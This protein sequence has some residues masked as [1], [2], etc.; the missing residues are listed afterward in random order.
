LTLPPTA[1]IVL[2]PLRD[3]LRP[4][5]A[6]VLVRDPE[7]LVDDRPRDVVER[8]RDE[9]EPR[10]RELE[11][12][13]AFDAFV[14]LPPLLEPFRELRDLVFE[15]LEE[16]RRAVL[17]FAC[18]IFLPPVSVLS[19][20]GVLPGFS[21]LTRANTGENRRDGPCNPPL[22]RLRRRVVLKA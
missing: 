3:A 21:S 20:P 6:R 5:R 19:N 7:L 14:L 10:L 1:S 22:A 4:L 11:L 9:L 18:A 13:R 2:W 17:A 15:P 8:E 16:L 12:L